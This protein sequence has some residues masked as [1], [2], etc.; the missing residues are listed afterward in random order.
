MKRLVLPSLIASILLP[1][2][3]LAN[4]DIDQLRA[5]IQRMK[6]QYEQRISTLEQRL[7]VAEK[8]ANKAET[9]ARQAKKQTKPTKKANSFN[10]AISVVLDGRYASFDNE[11]EEYEIAGF[12]L[13]GE[14][15]LGEEGFSVG[16]TEISASAN[17]DDKF[18]GKITAALHEHDGTTE[19]ELE[20]AFVQ[21]LGLGHGLTAKAG[22]F[23][24][25]FGYLNEQHQHSWSFA[26]APLIYR[27]LF[28]NQLVDDGL[29]LS[30]IAPTDLFLEVGA[31]VFRGARFPSAGEHSGVGAWSGF[32]N[33]GGDIGTDHSWLV[34]LGHWRASDVQGRTTGGHAHEHEG[35]DHDEHDDHG[36]AEM[37]SFT[38]DSK[39]NTVALIYKWARNGNLKNRHLTLQF[40]YFDRRE[41]GTINLLN[42]DPFETTTY[43][44]KQSGWYTQAV[45]QFMPQWQAGLRYDQLKSN[46]TGSEP[47]ILAEAGLD[48]H[49]HTPRRYSAMLQWVPSEFSR[50]RLQYNRDKSSEHTD[51][52]LF[53]QYTYSLGSHGAHQF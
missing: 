42:S 4:G 45:Y 35:E 34:E 1:A 8:T 51:N 33:I 28:G 39:I 16:H 21:T 40:E 53:L 32:A 13:G 6:Q 12:A 7:Q 43:Q 19:V 44:G 41:A 50:I 27:G 14:S 9:T 5:D 15:G 23:L 24:S 37:P 10:P 46:N 48:N 20:E 30:Y 2:S 52:Q 22:R 17:I 11:A 3:A 47:D 29:Q 26:D 38:G 36:V 31:E 18:Y 25:G 49:G